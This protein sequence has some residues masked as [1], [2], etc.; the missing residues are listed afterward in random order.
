MREL[1]YS[2]QFKKDSRLAQKQGKDL[3]ELKNVVARLVSGEM[4]DEK[5]KD[6]ALRGNYAGTRE[7]HVGP[8]WLLIYRITGNELHVLRM[9]SHAELFKK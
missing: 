4:L 6:H 9:G 2:S 5:L 8:D 3:G 7:C 1:F